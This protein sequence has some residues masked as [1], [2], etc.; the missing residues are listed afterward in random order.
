MTSDANP[1]RET[2]R[3]KAG[4]TGLGSI[5]VQDP[6]GLPALTPR[7][8]AVLALLDRRYSNKEIARELQVAPETV[9]KYTISIYEK[10]NVKGR[11]EAAT[12]GR[13]LGYLQ[14]PAQAPHPGAS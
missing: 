8:L 11:H 12:K 6:A 7:E 2:Q 1:T 9:K 10:L 4:A 13:A 5:G 14:P 3:A